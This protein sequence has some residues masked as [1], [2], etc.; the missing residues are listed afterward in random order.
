M[1]AKQRDVVK[2][3]GKLPTRSAL[4]V[5]KTWTTPSA[6]SLFNETWQRNSWRWHVYDSWTKWN[7]MTCLCQG[8]GLCALWDFPW[9]YH[10]IQ[11]K[12]MPYRKSLSSKWIFSITSRREAPAESLRIQHKGF[13]MMT[14]TFLLGGKMS[15]RESLCSSS[16]LELLDSKVNK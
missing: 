14:R 3:R 6:S 7:G 11:Y 8:Y 1:L 12:A 5:P 16:M 10:N 4:R 15:P 13:C 9:Q 2:H